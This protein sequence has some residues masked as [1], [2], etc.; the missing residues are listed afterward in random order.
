MKNIRRTRKGKYKV[1]EILHV[2]FSDK[3]FIIK[4][5]K[6]KKKYAEDVYGKPKIFKL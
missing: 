4:K 2:G 3:P 6:G 5:I 1:G